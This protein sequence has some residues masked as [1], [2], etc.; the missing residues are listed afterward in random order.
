M[1]SITRKEAFDCA[2]AQLISVAQVINNGKKKLYDF[3][4]ILKERSVQPILCLQP[5]DYFQWNE[6]QSYGEKSYAFAPITEPYN[7]LIMGMCGRPYFEEVGKFEK[8]NANTHPAKWIREVLTKQYMLL[9]YDCLGVLDKI[10]LAHDSSFFSKAH[11]EW[12]KYINKEDD[13]ILYFPYYSESE[14]NRIFNSF[15]KQAIVEIEE[16]YWHE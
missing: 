8:I 7:T 3:A 4:L 6:T 15:N 11:S 16:E 1:S 5:L 12:I 14:R 9:S 2:L 13:E 10:E